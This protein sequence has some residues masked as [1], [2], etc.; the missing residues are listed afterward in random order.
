MR[1]LLFLILLLFSSLSQA[2][3]QLDLQQCIGLAIENNIGVQQ[4]ENQLAITEVAVIQRKFSFLPNAGGQIG[5][6]RNIGQ[7]VDNFSQQIA[8]SPTTANPSL[9]GSLSLFGGLSK[10]NALKSAQADAAAAKYSL[11][12]LQ[13]D[14]RLNVALAYFQVIFSNDQLLIVNDRIQLLEKQLVQTERL[15]EAGSLTKG[16][17]YTLKAQLATERVNLVNAKNLSR[18][19]LLNLILSMNADPTQEYEL[20]RPDIENLMLQQG[21]ESLNSIVAGAVAFN[22]GLKS[23]KFQILSREHQIKVNRAG[24]MPTLNMT[25]GIGSFY[26]S[27]ARPL[28]GF[29]NDP[30]EGLIP[31]YGDA[32]GLGKQI[33]DNIGQAVGLSLNIPI[34]QNYQVRQGVRTAEL[35]LENTILGYENEKNLLYQSILMAY[36][37]AEA[38]YATFEATTEQIQAAELSFE[39]AQ[40]RYDAG[41]INFPT[42]LETLNNKTRSERELLR[43][44]YDFILKTKILDLYQGKTLQF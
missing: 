20:E 15:F 22:P 44:K 7:T 11:E 13:N 30:V 10:W 32:P 19:N 34:F 42:Y 35:N 18:Q 38:A 9:F 5:L 37:D 23:L 6:N 33:G 25:Y 26:S 8:E 17:V 29:E 39:F 36:Q 1:P 28:L 16:D 14:I 12:D 24:M 41:V 21:L 40:T 31:L 43:A 3:V 4:S 2:Q 27:S